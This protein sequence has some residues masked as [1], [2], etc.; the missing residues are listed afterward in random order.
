[1]D[2]E[3]T[4][5]LPDGIYIYK[6]GYQSGPFNVGEARDLLDAMG[7]TD[8]FYWKP[9]MSDWEPAEGLGQQSIRKSSSR[10]H[11]PPILIVD[12]DP[13][14][15][16][17]IKIQISPLSKVIISCV[18]AAEARAKLEHAINPFSC[19]ITDYMM[20]GEDGIDLVEW[21]K[22]QD[23]QLEVI[24]LTARDD[25]ET[26]KRA[27][28]SGIF[29]F[30]EKPIGEQELIRTVQSCIEKT[31]ANRHSSSERYKIESLI[32]KGGSGDVFRARDLHLNRPVAFKRLH[33]DR[34]FPLM[35]NHELIEE[36][37]RLAKMQNPHIV[38]VYDCSFDTEGPFMVMELLEG[39]TVEELIDRGMRLSHKRLSAF[40]LQCLDALRYAHEKGFLHLD[41]KPSNI[42]DVATNPDSVHVKILDFGIARFTGRAN[43]AVDMESEKILGS[44]LY[45]APER[46]NAGKLDARA[47]LYS[48]GCVLYH[49][50]SG[51]EP[52]VAETNHEIAVR[53][54]N[55]DILPLHQVCPEAPRKLSDWVMN[56]IQPHLDARPAT[57]AQ[58]KATF[59]ELS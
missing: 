8:A 16:E 46:F 44:P 6:S 19:V 2:T 57:A 50:I 28:R 53:H 41:I 45:M 59:P 21:I 56:L 15:R 42:M 17:L 39:I 37:L 55:H 18:N 51:E 26:I 13:L 27:L 47:D 9:T 49:L 4:T 40:I 36:A 10:L 11:Q 34:G 30:L 14:M 48:L 25:K 1:M 32:G 24:L 7:H 22:R 35:E 33:S 5:D 43:G 58:A 23:P 38:N 12:D 54:F 20:P 52:F 3:N 29:D 31:E